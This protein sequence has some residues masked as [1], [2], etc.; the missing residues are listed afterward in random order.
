MHEQT[1]QGLRY[2]QAA[3]TLLQRVA[4]QQPT[5]GLLEAADLQWW[6][7]T[8]RRTDELPQLFWCDDD[9]AP[10]AAAIATDWGDGVALDLI[11]MPDASAEQARQ[12]LERALRHAQALELGDVDIVVDRA[13][14]RMHQLLAG[15]GFVQD[16]DDKLDVA[17]A[18]LDLG[19]QRPSPVGAPALSPVPSP[20]LPPGYRLCDRTETSARPHHMI[21]RSGP[22]IEERLRQ[23]SLYR[24]DLDLL[25]L[26]SDDR[27]AA[28]GLFWFDPVSA[29]GLVE[30][31]RTEAA[32]QR[33]GLA[34][35]LLWAGI[36]RLARAGAARVKVCFQPG[37]AAAQALYLRAGFRPYKRTAVLSRPRGA[38]T[39]VA[40]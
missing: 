20:A 25:V 31:M 21:S 7:R 40:G 13:D 26:D 18:M 4:Q 17:L 15:H 34:G 2:L 12:V 9:G 24:A 27:L 32:H 1:L 19:G 39:A 10:T 28:Y 30:P 3:T 11:L 38:G 16:P 36:Q 35:H 14:T 33:R 23:T 29:T 22:Q 8:P 37:N 6:W 5:A